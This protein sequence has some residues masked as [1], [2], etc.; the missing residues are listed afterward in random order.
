MVEIK[1]R[2]ARPPSLAARDP[3]AL[4]K[5]HL[6]LCVDFVT[7]R[8]C[9]RSSDSRVW[10]FLPADKMTELSPKSPPLGEARGEP[11]VTGNPNFLLCFVSRTRSVMQEQKALNSC[12]SISDPSTVFF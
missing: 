5:N 7:S 12:R 2:M 11:G 10:G 4:L 9:S 6:D 8:G 3:S 1:V